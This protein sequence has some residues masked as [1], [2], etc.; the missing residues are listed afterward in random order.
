MQTKRSNQFF[1]HFLRCSYTVILEDGS[2]FLLELYS[3]R[4]R[5]GGWVD[6]RLELAII[7]S[8][9]ALGNSP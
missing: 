8:V 7:L 5:C 3:C 1:C 9:S 4:M 6:L 2:I